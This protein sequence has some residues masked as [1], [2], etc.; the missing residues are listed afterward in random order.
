[1]LLYLSDVVFIWPIS[2]WFVPKYPIYFFFLYL[3]LIDFFFGTETKEFAPLILDHFLWFWSADFVKKV[4][5]YVVSGLLLDFIDST[6]SQL[7]SPNSYFM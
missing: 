4:S 6:F 1:M 3:C 7:V 2:D 5:D